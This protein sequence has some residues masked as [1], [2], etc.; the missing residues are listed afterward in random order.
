MFDFQ[1]SIRRR[2]PLTQALDPQLFWARVMAR[3]EL[4]SVTILVVALICTAMSFFVASQWPFLAL[5]ALLLSTS[6]VL[7]RAQRPVGY[8]VGQLGLFLALL[9]GIGHSI[10]DWEVPE[11]VEP[12][13]SP[14]AQVAIVCALYLGCAI[15]L[16]RAQA[17]MRIRLPGKR[18]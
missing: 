9:I 16:R 18:L 13:L 7:L 12:I 3:T 15:L 6:L 5:M 2:V 1:T 8:Y 4:A 14:Y 10:G 17:E 11:H